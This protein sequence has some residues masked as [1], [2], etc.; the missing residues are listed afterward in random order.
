MVALN[1]RNVQVINNFNPCEPLNFLCKKYEILLY[2]K[3]GFVCSWLTGYSFRCGLHDAFPTFLAEHNTVGN[4]FWL[5]TIMSF[6][7]AVIDMLKIKSLWRLVLQTTSH[8][9]L[10]ADR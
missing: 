1:S 2:N 3:W 8:Y 10:L 4:T 6:T 5:G 9:F 7:Q